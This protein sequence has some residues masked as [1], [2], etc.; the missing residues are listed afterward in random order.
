MPRAARSDE[1]TES[2]SERAVKKERSR[3]TRRATRVRDNRPGLPPN[4]NRSP[5]SRSRDAEGGGPSLRLTWLHGPGQGRRSP[6]S[7]VITAVGEFARSPALARSAT[8]LQRGLS[9]AQRRLLPGAP[10]QR[11]AELLHLAVEV[12]PLDAEVAGG[13]PEVAP[14]RGQ[15]LEDVLPLEARARHPQRQRRAVVGR[16]AAPSC[17][18]RP[19]RRG[20]SPRRARRS[21]RAAPSGCAARGRCPA[22]AAARGTR[23]RA[24]VRRFGLRPFST[25]ARRR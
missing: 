5:R 15:P 10:A 18:A 4:P 11:D 6:P 19:S 14:V 12:R 1:T 20:A 17:A 21:R 24:G 8:S 25:L 23:S 3:P 7:P 2:Q 16:R 22:R 13:V 9:V